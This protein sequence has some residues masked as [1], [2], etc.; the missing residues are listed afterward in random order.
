MRQNNLIRD[1]LNM[2]KKI[3]QNPPATTNNKKREKKIK[4]VR[5][6]LCG[7]FDENDYYHYSVRYYY[8]WSS[9]RCSVN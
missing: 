7:F 4:Y 8:C 1:E 9:A 3:I 5:V 6:Y 2:P